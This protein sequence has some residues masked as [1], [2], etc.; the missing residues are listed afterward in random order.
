MV[1]WVP[2]FLRGVLRGWDGGGLSSWC[3]NCKR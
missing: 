2:S 1:D 3:A